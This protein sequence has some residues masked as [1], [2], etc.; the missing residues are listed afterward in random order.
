MKKFFVT[1]TIALLTASLLTAYCPP[2][3]DDVLFREAKILI[4]DKQWEEAGRIL[5]RLMRDFP[6]SELFAQAMFYSGR[7]LKQQRGK[8]NL[9][10]ETFL[11]FL[12]RKDL[13]RDL[14]REAEYEIID[15]ALDLYE[16]G[17]KSHIQKIEKRLENP[18]RQVRNYAAIR[19]SYV[20]DRGIA[21]RALPVLREILDR[22]SEG[23]LRDRAKLA[24][25]RIDPDAADTVRE[26]AFGPS[27][28]TLCIRAI[29]K[30]SG[31]T[32]FSLNIP[33]ALA[34]LALSAIPEE[35]RALMRRE[36][37]DLDR[38]IKE[39]TSFRGNIIEFEDEETLVKIWIK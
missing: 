2:Q 32:S 7:C 26:K 35:E 34:D 5:D 10:L 36:G 17:R 15:L 33:W 28:A 1:A 39:L 25:L 11:R 31:R 18:D 37:Y 21:T 20:P 27:G 38:I 9:A 19:L 30:T 14:A 24:I 3:D 16:R 23:D 8:E 13:N 29:K 22:E 4:F 6:D 12:E